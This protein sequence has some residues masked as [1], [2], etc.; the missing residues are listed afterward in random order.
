[1]K[2]PTTS[3]GSEMLRAGLDTGSVGSRSLH[4]FRIVG[5]ACTPAHYDICWQARQAKQSASFRAAAAVAS[6]ALLAACSTSALPPPVR[7]Q[8]DSAAVC[9]ALRADL[10]VLYHAKSTDAETIAN[11]RR[12]NARFRASCP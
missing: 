2:I 1:M 4:R 10:P 12:A 9:E 5:P 8:A 6:L 3:T 11:I 7:I